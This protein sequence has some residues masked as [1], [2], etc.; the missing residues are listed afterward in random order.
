MSKIFL[1]PKPRGR[2]VR[3]RIRNRS[4][5]IASMAVSILVNLGLVF[6]ISIFYSNQEKSPPKKNIPTFVEFELER[7][8]PKK[9]QPIKIPEHLKEKIN[10]EV[11]IDKSK[12]MVATGTSD[13]KYVG[14][15]K[16]PRPKQ[17]RVPKK[18]TKKASSRRPAVRK[19]PKKAKK[20]AIKKQLVLKIKPVKKADLT[21][22]EKV[23][24]VK[25]E[26]EREGGYARHLALTRLALDP[27][28]PKFNSDLFSYSDAE[29]FN[30]GGCSGCLRF[31][32][33]TEKLFKQLRN[34]GKILKKLKQYKRVK[35][36]QRQKR[37]IIFRLIRLLKSPI[38]NKK[39][40]AKALAL[41]G[42]DARSAIPALEEACKD[43]DPK[44][45][46][47]AKRA[48]NRITP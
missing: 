11:V 10:D 5:L 3:D 9:K 30:R 40:A 33:K 6:L 29:L 15:P 42:K 47:A 41:F 26:M 35:L 44:V 23:A 38:G 22:A 46:K 48:L 7:S 37:V 45:R 8:D 21:L 27:S 18:P 20:I 14:R 28:P 31:D 16:R 19:K 32:K 4:V 43:S 25:A 12:K 24:Q 2:Q 13:K 17:R 36:S 1:L 39:L 34:Y